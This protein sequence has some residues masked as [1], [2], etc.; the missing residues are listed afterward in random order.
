MAKQ[1]RAKFL[2]KVNNQWK[3]KLEPHERFSGYLL[4]EPF[5]GCVPVA[6]C[7]LAIGEEAGE[8]L[9]FGVHRWR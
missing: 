6:V 9:V 3:E 4:E 7:A 1:Q 2:L 5:G 8:W